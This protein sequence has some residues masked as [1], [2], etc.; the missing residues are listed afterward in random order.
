MRS[1]IDGGTKIHAETE[2]EK[3]CVNLFKE[4][5]ERKRVDAEFYSNPNKYEINCF[6]TIAK[7]LLLAL[8]EGLI[9]ELTIYNDTRKRRKDPVTGRVKNKNEGQGA[10]QTKKLAQHFW[11][12]SAT[13]NFKYC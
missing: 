9:S 2:E 3:R 7:E 10:A 4:I 6:L 13:A 12:I 1:K 11:P 8:K 5:K